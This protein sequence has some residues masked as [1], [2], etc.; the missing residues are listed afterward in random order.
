MH[1][2]ERYD[3]NGYPQGLK[4]EDIPK[5]ARLL[6]V[7]DAYDAMNSNRPYR[8]KLS[9]GDIVQ[10]LIDESGKQFDPV[11]VKAFLSL[12]QERGID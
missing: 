2:H 3:G 4:G 8:K 12:L 11:I 10:E 1:H 6:A 5:M 9:P 7:I